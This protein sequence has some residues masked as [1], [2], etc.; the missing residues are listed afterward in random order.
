MRKLLYSF[1]LLFVLCTNI[2]AQIVNIENQ[3]KSD[4]T[5]VLVGSTGLSIDF[6]KS[7]STIF[8]A[9][10]STKIQYY[11]NKNIYLLMTDLQ[12]MQID[13]VRYL[14]NGFMHLRY[15]HNF[16]NE[17]LIAEAFTQVQFNRIQKIN[18]RFLWGG[19]A[20]YVI[21]NN[22][23][24]KIHAGTALMYEFELYIDDVY[25][26]MVRMSDYLTVMYK[27]TPHFTFRLSSYYQ[28]RINQFSNFRINTEASAEAVIIKNLSFKTKFEHYYDSKPAPAVQKIFYSLHN[29]LV[30]RFN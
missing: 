4:T 30:W 2:D 6:N 25:Q 20:R 11:Q 24:I 17:W 10:N 23:K 27:P 1:A 16:D 14:N 15:N 26:D 29:G 7:T 13:T 18:R 12:M 21:L 5:K 19:G 3:R 22:E 8:T 9:K 28:P